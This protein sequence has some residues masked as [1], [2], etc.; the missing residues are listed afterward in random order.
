MTSKA[1]K[2][3]TRGVYILFGCVLL[4]CAVLCLFQGVRMQDIYPLNVSPLLL[5][6]GMAAWGAALFGVYCLTRRFDNFLKKHAAPIFILALLLFFALCFA[7]AKAMAMALLYDARYLFDG[8]ASLAQTGSFGEN[9]WYFYR[10]QNNVAPAVY[11]SLFFRL[12]A[13]FRLDAQTA[14]QLLCA[15]GTTA[16]VFFICKIS[17]MLCGAKAACMSLALCFAT[18]PMYFFC[19]VPYT[20]TLSLPYAVGCMYFYL[21]AKRA[22]TLKFRCIHMLFA[23]VMIAVG[24]AVKPTVYIAAIAISIDLAMD[25]LRKISFKKMLLPLLCTVA[26]CVALPLLQ[27]AYVYGGGL[28]DEQQAQNE[29]IPF[30]HWIMLGLTSNG[31]YNDEDQEFTINQPSPEVR[32]AAINAEISRRIA[33][34]SP[35][36]W[37][38]W[39]KAKLLTITGDGTYFVSTQLDDEVLY[40]NALHGIVLLERPHYALF[41]HFCTSLYLLCL[42]AAAVHA[43][44]DKSASLLPLRLALLGIIAF[45]MMWEVS[46]RYMYNFSPLLIICAACG[47]SKILYCCKF[48]HNVAK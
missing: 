45:L 11:L 31:A 10:Y 20:D 14:G 13:I 43:L 12:G 7:C 32:S 2:V 36:D 6:F 26:V 37:L 9:E 40:P 48:R 47:M 33:E 23:G 22:Q 44:L 16:A 1:E 4:V 29:H 46:G 30:T 17:H 34:K 41:Y 3:L 19:A 15:F 35:L 21:K 5:I 38:I 27:N 42:L 25:F 18:L 24:A 39:A 8:A 28:L